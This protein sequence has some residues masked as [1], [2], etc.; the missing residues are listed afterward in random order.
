[1]IERNGSYLITQHEL[2]AAGC[3]GQAGYENALKAGLLTVVQKAKGCA[4]A[5]LDWTSLPEAIKAMATAHLGG[6]PE[7]VVASQ[8]IERHLTVCAQDEQHIDGFVGGNGL[9]LAPAKREQ[10]K[11]AAA[12][13]HLLA[14]VDAAMK[15]GGT[16]A[17]LAEYGMTTLAL[18]ETVLAYVKANRS[19]LPS[20]FPTSFARLESR[21]RA[22]LKARAAGQPGASSL[23]HGGQGNS[24][25]AK[26]QS[27]EQ[28]K[29]LLLVCS[30]HQNYG[31]RRSASD[32]NRIAAVK[33][34]PAIG[35]N[36]VSR[37]L[38][39]GDNGRAATIYAKGIG[40]YSNNYG[41]VVHRSRPTQP[42]YMWVHDGTD[43]E[44]L[45]RKE[46]GGKAS[47]HHRKMV[48]VVV[49]PHSWY[50]V[51]FAIGEEDTIEL[52]QAA[53]RDAVRHM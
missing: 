27:A 25:S 52:T 6:T 41:I 23:V 20:K 15:E 30:R 45:Y 42:T 49:D 33:G 16:R 38:A 35:A 53:V 46:I 37:F 2:A 8:V 26:L 31:T 28:R 40:Q 4:P 36:V 1:M 39:D 34:W 13:M 11:K 14:T 21:K 43:Y 18:K 10:L 51:G 9:A 50:P 5:L 29:A 22:Y 7:Q 24:N 19:R 32:Y 3:L 48:V 17:V 12:V 47:H 44:L